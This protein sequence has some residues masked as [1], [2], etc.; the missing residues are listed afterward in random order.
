[1]VKFKAKS[2]IDI[3]GARSAKAIGSVVTN[4]LRNNID[5]LLNVGSLFAMGLSAAMILNAGYMGKKFDGNRRCRNV[6]CDDYHAPPGLV[7][8]YYY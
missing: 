7:P 2:W 5:S 8:Y 4:A 3:F 1:M 6:W